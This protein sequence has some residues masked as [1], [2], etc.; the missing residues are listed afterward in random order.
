ML[1][2]YTMYK[3]KEKYQGMFETQKV[4]RHDK[5]RK[6]W[7]QYQNKRKSQTGQDQASATGPSVG[8]SKRRSIFFEYHLN[9]TQKYSIIKFICIFCKI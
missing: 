3:A 6:E 8:R 1:M 4:R 2:L 9:S 5:L 7:S